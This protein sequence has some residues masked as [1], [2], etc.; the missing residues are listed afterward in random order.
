MDVDDGGAGTL[1]ELSG[2]IESECFGGTASFSTLTAL[3]VRRD[4]I[5]P[6]AG[7]LA[8][9]FQES[10]SRILYGAD[11]SVSIDRDADGVFDEVLPNCLDPRL[12]QC[13]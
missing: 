12:L 1:F 9:G 11:G 10:M 8:I 3:A 5:C 2:N 6:S 13:G 7:L 4:E